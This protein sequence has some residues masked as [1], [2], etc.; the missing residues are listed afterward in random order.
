MNSAAEI[1]VLL[2]NE[3]RAGDVI[4]VMSNGNFDGL[5]GRLLETFAKQAKTRGVAP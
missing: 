1:A 3:A 4:L 5:T 2:G